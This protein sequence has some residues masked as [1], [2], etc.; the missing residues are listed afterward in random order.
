LNGRQK[1]LGLEANPVKMYVTYYKPLYYV[2]FSKFISGKKGTVD[3]LVGGE[4]GEIV[5]IPPSPDKMTDQLEEA[6]LGETWLRMIQVRLK[7]L[8]RKVMKVM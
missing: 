1:I 3:A 7:Y 6:V 5:L 2:I 4:D 8:W